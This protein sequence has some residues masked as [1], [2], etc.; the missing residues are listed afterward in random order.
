MNDSHPNPASAPADTQA[1]DE[2]LRQALA[3]LEA[4]A[5]DRTVLDGC[6]EDQRARLHRAIAAIYHPEPKLRRQ[7]TKER[8][9]ER[10]AEAIR[11]ADALLDSTGIRELRRKPVFTTPNYFPPQGFDALGNPQST[12]ADGTTQGQPKPQITRRPKKKTSA[13]TRKKVSVP[14][15][16]KEGN[17]GCDQR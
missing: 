1:P 12:N 13:S 5:A 2:R 14:G 16:C 6:P 9:R 4:I 7:K 11:R 15:V 10:N 17:T 3:L 8:E